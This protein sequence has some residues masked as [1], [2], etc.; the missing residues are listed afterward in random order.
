MCADDIHADLDDR[1]WES[2]TSTCDI[3][4]GECDHNYHVCECGQ[5][6]CLD[7][8]AVCD[9]CNKTVC[10]KCFDGAKNDF[11]GGLNVN[12]SG[13]HICYECCDAGKMPDI[14]G[15]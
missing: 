14:L 8:T 13:L 12:N 15:E 4:G 5:I 7:C 10:K 2:Q 9:G 11:G 6:V 3:C 1:T